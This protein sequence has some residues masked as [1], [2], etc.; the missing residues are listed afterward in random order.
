MLGGLLAAL[1]GLGS[2]AGGLFGLFGKKKNPMDEANKYLNQIP[3]QMQ[4]YYQP[5]QQAGLDTLKQLQGEYGKLLGDPNAMYNKFAEGYKESPG[6]QFKLKQA[7]G[8]GNNA[9]AAG[10]FAGS[11]EHEQLSMQTANDIAS[12]DFNNYLSQ[13]AGLYGQ[14]LQGTQ[15]LENQG[16]G[17]NTDYANMLGQLLGQQGKMAYEGAN[18]A[19]TASGQNWGNIFG[20]LGQIG[21]GL[22][23]YN[24]QQDLMN[25]LKQFGGR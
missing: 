14:G 3:G 1:P 6:Y 10:G 15:G 4:P 11:P 12:Q 18:A 8:A 16:Y 24:K 17:A 22:N 20:G 5:Y 23:S 9:A 13:I 2:L 25:Y 7:L 19:N 21:S